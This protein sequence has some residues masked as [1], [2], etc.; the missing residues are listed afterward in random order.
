MGTFITTKRGVNLERNSEYTTEMVAIDCS[1]ILENL[2]LGSYPQS[3]EDVLHL[4]KQGV[5]AILN[6]QSDDDF[7]QRGIR[8]DLFWAF[9]VRQGLSVERVPIVDFEPDDLRRHLAQAVA[10]LQGLIEAGHCVYVHC[11]AGLNRSPTTVIAWL[12]QTRSLGMEEAVSFVSAR[13][14]VVPYPEV[15]SWWEQKNR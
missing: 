9:Y 11:T 12:M 15:L 13:R 7:S 14:E 6:L 5:T 2:W 10:S 1:K 3:P 4:K 8:W